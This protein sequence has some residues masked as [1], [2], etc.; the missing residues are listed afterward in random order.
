[1]VRKFPSPSPVFCIVY[2]SVTGCIQQIKPHVCHHGWQSQE[3]WMECFWKLYYPPLRSIFQFAEI[4]W[5]ACFQCFPFFGG[6][7]P[8][9]KL[10]STVKSIGYKAF[11]HFQSLLVLPN[12]I[13]LSNIG[14][15]II[16]RTAI[17]HIT[18]A[19]RVE[20]GWECGLRRPMRG[21]AECDG[22]F[23][24]S[25]RRVTIPQILLQLFHYNKNQWQSQ[26]K[27]QRFCTSDKW[28]DPSAYLKMNPHATT[29]TIVALSLPWTCFE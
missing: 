24:A 25:Y 6:V 17:H 21:T 15:G 5:R 29:D 14:D 18:R 22:M 10:P 3:D 7:V 9:I 26:S 8:P 11:L 2:S 19:A 12:N 27:R 1:V 4:Y 16:K 23:E 13:D 28:N 20:Y